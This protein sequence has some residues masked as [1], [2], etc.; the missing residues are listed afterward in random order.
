MDPELERAKRRID[1]IFDAYQQAIGASPESPLPPTLTKG[2]VYEAWILCRVLEHLHQQENY[3]A[4]L[5]QSSTVVLKSSGGPINRSYPYFRL[6]RP[7]SPSLEVWTDVTFLALSAAARSV[8]PYSAD[9]CD[10]H[11]LDVVVVPAGTEGRPSHAQIRIG[12]E[13]KN[14]TYEKDMLRAL[15]GVRRE[16]SLL[17]DV[18]PT[19][20]RT[21]PRHQVPANPPSCLL[22][23]GTDRKILEFA[24]PGETFGVDFIY[25]PLP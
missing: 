2:K 21:W 15:L 5:M 8:D 4:T 20:F 11:E 9:R 24:P 12:V 1:R 22:A 18:Q 14:L 25:E 23:F 17:A 10:Y 16:L 3:I 19:G 7:G 13:C 6:D